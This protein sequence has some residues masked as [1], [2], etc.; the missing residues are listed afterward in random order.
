V[1]FLLVRQ[2]LEDVNGSTQADDMVRDVRGVGVLGFPRRDY[3]EGVES[4]VFELDVGVVFVR[5]VKV[6]PQSFA[7]EVVGLSVGVVWVVWVASEPA[8]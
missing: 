7:V 4:G 5:E 2:G 6:C 3:A 1:E 8:R